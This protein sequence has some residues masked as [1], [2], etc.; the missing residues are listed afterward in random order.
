MW[1]HKSYRAHILLKIPLAVLDHDP[2]NARK[3]LFYSHLGWLLVRQDTPDDGDGSVDISDLER[4]AVVVWQ[5]R[6][7]VPLAICM[8][9]VFP[10]LVAGIGWEDWSGGF[11]WASLFRVVF[12]RHCTYLVNSLAHWAGEQPFSKDN[13]SRDNWISSFLTMGEGYHNF[14]HTF[15]TD[16]RNG[17]RWYDFDPS[18]W[19]IWSFAQLGLALDLNRISDC[20]IEKH[21]RQF[22]AEDG[23]TP[24]L[25]STDLSRPHPEIGWDDYVKMATKHDRA[26]IAIAGFV[27]DVS[28]FMDRHPGGE[29]L[30]QQAIG[31]DATTMFHGGVVGHSRAANEILLTMRVYSIRS[32]GLVQPLW[33]GATRDSDSKEK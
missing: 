30:I 12:V 5:D 9:V 20:V 29:V 7:Y 26:L 14:H 19:V 32:G 27:Y 15:P 1:A 28:D 22:L 24:T 2:Y 8:S 17:V 6:Y 16:Y 23:G 31:K 4:D 33:N 21:R 10:T 25:E 11:F 18:K 3:G 13:T